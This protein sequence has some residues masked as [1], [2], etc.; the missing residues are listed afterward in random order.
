MNNRIKLVFLLFLGTFMLVGFAVTAS[1][2]KNDDNTRPGW[3]YGDK[4]YI[5]TGPPGQSVRP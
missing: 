3:G 5:H 1:A 2:K 4:N